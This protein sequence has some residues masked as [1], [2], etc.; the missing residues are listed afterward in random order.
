MQR[1]A[2]RVRWLWLLVLV[3]VI[4]GGWFS[5]KPVRAALGN[6][7]T[8]VR[9]NMASSVAPGNTGGAFMRCFTVSGPTF[10]DNER[11]PAGYWLLVTDI[12]VI[13]EAASTAAAITDVTLYDAYGTNGRTTN[14]RL[15]STDSSSYGVHFTVPYLVLAEGHRLEVTT[16]AYAGVN[17]RVYASGLLVTNVNYLPLAA[18]N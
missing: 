16:A 10:V 2:I 5:V 8:P 1:Q 14:Y 3:A 11:V 17:V 18:S 9:L 6:T 15:R 13:P 7:G 4:T 12:E